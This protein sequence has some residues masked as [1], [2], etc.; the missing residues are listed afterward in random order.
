MDSMKLES[1]SRSAE[2]DIQFSSYASFFLFS[3][4]QGLTRAMKKEHHP[5]QQ[6]KRTK[7]EI[8]SFFIWQIKSC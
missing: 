6:Q 2:D 3:E 5:N 8:S 7:N 1:E 4:F